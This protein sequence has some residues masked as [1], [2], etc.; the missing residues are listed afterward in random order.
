[1]T[2]KQNNAEKTLETIAPAPAISP[3]KAVETRKPALAPS[4]PKVEAQPLSS[5]AA[6]A[7]VAEVA[8][9]PKVKA[10]AKPAATKPAVKAKA[11]PAPKKP[12]VKA[13]AKRVSK[14]KIATPKAAAAKAKIPAAPV[15]KGL[16]DMN[17]FVSKFAEEAKARVSSFGS[18][19]GERTQEAF[20]KSSKM[21]EEAAAFNQSNIDAVVESSK[22]AAKNIEVLR[23]E[24]IAFARKS[25]EDSNA[26]LQSFA[27]VKSPTDFFKLYAEN[28]KKMF[29]AA[30]A[31]TSK[32][33]E[34]MV[35]MSNESFA[36]ISNRMSV[37]TSQLKVA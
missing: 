21:A 9:K 24:S 22:I 7:K 25:F 1:M 3:A 5:E 2:E 10:A 30:I 26:V 20:A 19:F 32:N 31:Q 23:D 6:P 17:E 8:P 29:D 4:A 12:A 27:S 18:Q 13:A 11:K 35:K 33:S 37:I 34:L 28:S 36:P 14:P 15:S 16:L